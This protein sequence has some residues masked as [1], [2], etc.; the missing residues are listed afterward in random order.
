MKAF[1]TF[2][3][4]SLKREIYHTKMTAITTSK[5]LASHPLFFAAFL[6]IGNFA[7]E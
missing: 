5:S 7:Y 3:F 6:V 2:D 1:T 4:K